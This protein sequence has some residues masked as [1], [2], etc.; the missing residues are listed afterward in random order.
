MNGKEVFKLAVPAMVSGAKTVLA[1]A[2]ID[3]SQVRWIIPHQANQ[4]I[5]NAVTTRLGAAPEQ[6]YSNIQEYGNTSAASVGICLDE[7]NRSGRLQH[8][9]MVLATSFGAGLTWASVL[10]RW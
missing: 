6:V 10:I 2:G 8:G 7:L 3:I 1:E 5:I 4:R 9:D